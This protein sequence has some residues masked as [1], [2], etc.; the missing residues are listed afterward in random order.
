[1]GGRNGC[2]CRRR[3]CDD[4]KYEECVTDHDVIPSGLCFELEATITA[5]IGT[6][7]EWAVHLAFIFPAMCATIA[8]IEPYG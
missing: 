5:P 7:P 1:M 6:Q 3:R 4:G 2:N 8:E